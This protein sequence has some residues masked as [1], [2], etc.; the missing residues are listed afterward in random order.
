MSGFEYKIIR[1]NR[2][3]MAIE[4]TETAEV[5]V[6]IPFFVTDKKALEFASSKTL[7]IEKAVQK[8]RSKPQ[9]CHNI[10]PEEIK[11]LKQKAKEYLPLRTEYYSRLTGL[12]YK[13]IKITSA[14]KRF[15][16]CNGK[17]GI[18]FSYMLMLYP[19]VAIDYVIVHE[20]CHTK[21]HNHSKNFWD[22][23]ATYMPDFKFRRELLK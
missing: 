11:E 1:S 20:L 15:G 22:L 16:S 21:H 5:L 13:S 3:T 6:R 10:T 14:K 9:N 7:W 8:Q 4:V 17:N 23:V 18:C 12:K 19:K 2:R